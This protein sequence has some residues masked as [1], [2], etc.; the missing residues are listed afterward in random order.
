M[1]RSELFNVDG[2]SGRSVLLSI[3]IPITP[4]FSEH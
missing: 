4:R 1:S 2:G 3:L